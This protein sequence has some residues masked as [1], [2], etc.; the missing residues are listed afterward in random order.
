MSARPTDGR[1]LRLGLV[2]LGPWGRNFVRTLSRIEGA[3][4]SAVASRS[5]DLSVLKDHHCRVHAQWER[6][7]EESL[8]GV[9]V[10]TPPS[11]HLAIAE[12]FVAGGI[13]ALI[14]KPLCLD[15]NAAL[16]F[17]DAVNRRRGLVMVDH[18]HLFSPAFRLLKR[19]S[20]LLGRIT[21][22]ASSSGR[23][24]PFRPDVS[25][26]WDWG[27]HDVA[28]ALDLLGGEPR[29]VTGRRNLREPAGDG[30][31][32]NYDI[33][34]EFERGVRAEIAV[35][36]KLAPVRRIEVAHQGGALVY[37]DRMERKLTFRAQD[38][39]VGAQL[40]QAL[41]ASDLQR[42][43]LDCVLEAFCDR[44]RARRFDPG[45]LDLAVGVVRVLESVERSLDEKGNAQP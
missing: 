27:S 33:S 22:I 24:G 21:G 45:Q 37:D 23:H 30:Y 5:T 8:D 4:L 42:P 7:L 32:E 3:D 12:R 31:A 14:E 39:D 16:R 20:P 18:I 1:D 15:L 29:A 36:N 38:T 10:A 25:A 35:G 19:L 28:M 6:L 43:P 26:L 44:I 11:T 9:I 40:R 34:L 2:G 13:G 17:R 41:A